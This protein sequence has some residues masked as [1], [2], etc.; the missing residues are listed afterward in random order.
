MKLIE[1]LD[2]PKDIYP[3]VYEPA[4]VVGTV[5][6]DIAAE[7]NLSPKTLVIMGGGDAQLG[8]VGVGAVHANNAVILGGTFW[9]Q[10]VNVKQPVAEPEAKIRINAHAVNDLWQYEGISFQIG[11]VMRWFRD[12][13]CDR[14]KGIAKELHVSSYSILS[15]MAKDVPPGAYGI[16]PIFSDLMDYLHWKHAAPSLLNFNI[17]EPEKYNKAAIFRSLMENAAYNSLGNLKTIAAMTG[18]FPGEVIFAG[19]ASYSPIWCGI[20][21]DVLGVPVKVPRIKE[22]TAL[23]ALLCALIGSGRYQNFGEAVADICS[24]EAIYFPSNSIHQIYKE[25]YSNWRAVYHKLLELSD[26]GLL[27]YMW[28]APGE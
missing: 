13:F 26:M 25:Y 22:A 4:T 23:G 14:E 12:A 5:K 21:A 9:Q 10:E 1:R 3:K 17:N 6:T 8:T 27:S 2:L 11:L 20:L 18:Y 24:F 16:M 7:L 19:G 15:E 28:K